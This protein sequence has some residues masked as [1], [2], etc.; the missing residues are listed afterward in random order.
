MV[1]PVAPDCYVRVGS[2]N[3]RYRVAGASG[4]PVLLI[5][6]IGSYVENWDSNLLPLA[7]QHRVYALDLVGFGRS[8]KPAAPYTIDYFADFVRDFLRTQGLERAHIVGSSMGGIIA[9]N[10]AIRHPE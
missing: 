8:D 9:M 10:L 7:E 3:T 6:G 4:S 5:H 2:V 1:T